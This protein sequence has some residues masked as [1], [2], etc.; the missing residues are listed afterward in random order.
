M[1]TIMV[2]EDERIV[3]RDL[4]KRLQKLGYT[5]SAVVSSGIK[6][7]EKTK[8]INPDLVLMDIVLRGDMDGI[9]AAEIIR[10]QLGVPVVYVTAYADEE[11]LQRAKVTE[12]YGYILK[13]FEDR[14]LHTAIEI[15]LYKHEVEKKVK[16]SEQWLSITLKSIGDGV[17]ATDVNGSVIFMNPLAEHLT[18]WRQKEA[19]GTPLTTV[20]FTLTEETRQP[21]NLFEKIM[22][23]DKIMDLAGNAIL[24]SKEG[25]ERTIAT[26]GA[27][28]RDETNAIL[29]TVLVFRDITEKRRMEEEMA[30]T[31]KLESL[32]TLA[33]GIAHD[34][35][36][37]LTAIMGNANLAKLYATDI[38][39]TEKLTK[40]EKASLQA[41]D[42]TQ[43]LLTFSRGG[44]PIKETTSITAL[45]EDTVTFALRGSNV[46]CQLVVPENLW[47]VDVDAGQISQVINNVVINADHAMPEGGVITVE[48]ENVCSEVLAEKKKY[49]K[50]S[51]ADE[52]VGIPEE[53]VPRIFEPYFT[54]KQKG[55]GLGLATAYSIVKNHDGYIT[56][57]SVLGEGTTIC[58]FLP[59]CEKGKK[60]KG[61]EPVKGEGRVLLMDD[62]ESILEAA[63]EVLQYLGYTV[64]FARDGKEAVDAYTKAL[65]ENP[66]DVVIMDLTIPGGMGGKE[67]IKTL[68][69]VDPSVKA[70][71]S[72]GYSNDPIMAN[73]K[74]VGFKGVV[75]K[76]YTIEELSKTLQNV[77]KDHYKSE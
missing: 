9:T 61:G 42:L 19:A 51:I 34:F 76:P 71:V 28:I 41:K 57:D 70:I 46:T 13:P 23:T 45:I 60:E 58:I 38:K 3:A 33:G 52:G 4:Q 2:V 64:E 11:T 10:S 20:F 50:I 43:Q 21:Q 39:V 7:V 65:K 66:F 68:L 53:Y 6:A 73:Y 67:A 56:V 48:A 47:P 69:K 62:E 44:A 5:V 30:R 27:P 14:E 77:L 35:N 17:I 72:S 75:T 31:E 25:T 37:I 74:D 29:G 24:V 15:A 40:I 32:S 63:G 1:T 8:E 55:S 54:T 16:E 49:V 12:P 36:N 26:S 59:A 18:G 22:K